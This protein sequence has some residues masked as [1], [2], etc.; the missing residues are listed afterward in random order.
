MYAAVTQ[1]GCNALT[2]VASR[3]EVSHKHTTVCSE[4]ALEAPS[5]NYLLELYFI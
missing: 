3:F 4:Q 1:S 5:F 2:N